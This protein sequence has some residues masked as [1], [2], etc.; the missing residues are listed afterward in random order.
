MLLATV[1]ITA[2]VSYN[3]DNPPCFWGAEGA[4]IIVVFTFGIRMASCSYW[5][6]YV[7]Y[8]RAIQDGGAQGLRFTRLA[9]IYVRISPSIY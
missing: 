5:T 8:F 6:T 2:G 9:V 4:P 1:V 3:L 7:F